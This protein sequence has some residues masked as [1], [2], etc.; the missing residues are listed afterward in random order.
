MMWS[1]QRR[2]ES[3]FSGIWTMIQSDISSR[4]VASWGLTLLPENQYP[5]LFGA[6]PNEEILFG[7]G[8]TTR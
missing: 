8:E 6:T 7:I 5:N 4:E 2:S 1:E 3:F